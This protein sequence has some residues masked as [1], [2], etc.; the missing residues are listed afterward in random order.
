MAAPRLPVWFIP[1]GGGPCFFM[2]PPPSAP[3]TWTGM[4]AYLRGI[5]AT[6]GERPRAL[7]VISAHWLE[8]RP[9]VTAA[10]EPSLIYDYRGFPPHT[11]Q[12]RYPAPGDPAL[13]A[14]ICRLLNRAGIDSAADETRG[15]DHGVFVPLLL[16]YPNA[17]IPTVQLS[18][19]MSLDPAEH[20]A[21][22]RALASL[23]DEGVLIIG[24]GL[25][26]HNLQNLYRADPRIIQIAEKFDAWLTAAVA[27]P[28]AERN[29]ALTAW[30]AAPGARVS[31]PSED[32]L[33]PLMVA[34]GAAAEDLGVRD[35]SDH[36]FGAP[37]SGYR[38]G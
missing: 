37:V 2:D 22:G 11:Y 9:T 15:F 17:D 34:A 31:H 4:A 19:S 7:L 24:S 14:D 8:R 13:A 26:F 16:L 3:E 6:I 35:Y 21:I 5:P 20:I 1:H 36:I 10:A 30:A 38:F 32:H 27:G 12:L 25:S 28:E 23:R 18:L 29:A 33:I